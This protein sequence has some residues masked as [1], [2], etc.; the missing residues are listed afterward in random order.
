[1]HHRSIL[2]TVLVSGHNTVNT[3]PRVP[4]IYNG[5]KPHRPGVR[6]YA[7]PDQVVLE[8]RRMRETEDMRPDSIVSALSRQGYVVTVS[9]VRAISNYAYRAHLVPKNT[10][11]SYLT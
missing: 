3:A 7:L 9:A 11:I 5:P 2:P 1:M 4:A 8:I 10:Q 6:E